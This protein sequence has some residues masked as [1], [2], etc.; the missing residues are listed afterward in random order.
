MGASFRNKDEIL[1]LA[2]C[3]RLTISPQLLDELANSYNDALAQL[4][5]EAE[6]TGNDQTRLKQL[7]NEASDLFDQVRAI[8]P[9]PKSSAIAI[10]RF[11]A[12][13]AD[14]IALIEHKKSKVSWQR[15]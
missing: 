7:E 13:L 8:R 4:K 1:E 6:N 5:V 2:G 15:F 10:E 14:K 12:E 9:V 3:D 11:I